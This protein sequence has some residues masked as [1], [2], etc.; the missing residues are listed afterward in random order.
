ML[1]HVPVP[2]L[3]YQPWTTADEL[4]LPRGPWQPD[5]TPRPVVPTAEWLAE[6][7]PGISTA[8]FEGYYRTHSEGW[9]AARATGVGGSDVAAIV[10]CSKWTSRY[11]LWALR[12][13]KVERVEDRKNLN[14]KRWGSRLEAVLL[15]EFA[16]A[17]PELLVLTWPDGH[18]AA[19]VHS[20]RAY[21]RASPDALA[22]DFDTGLWH[23]VEVK[24]ARYDD[25]W[26]DPDTWALTVPRYYTTQDQWY[27][28]AF[29]WGDSFFA[30]LFTGSDYR[31]L[32]V[33]A[34]GWEQEVNRREVEAFLEEVRTGAAPA[35]D[36]HPGTLA[37]VRRMHPEIERD[38]VIELDDEGRVLVAAYR[39]MV[40]AESEYRQASAVVLAKMGQAHHGVNGKVRVASRQAQG[41]GAPF[42]KM[43]VK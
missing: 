20:E 41:K 24:T 32:V 39:A 16:E 11:E 17:H 7:I 23:I 37:T 3:T 35:M 13:G 25:E 19:F 38:T 21:Q 43:K 5:E 29:G 9:H 4:T 34:D 2:A 31:E 1:L 6:V 8:R 30:V 22:Y 15:E 42:L 14:E 36:E 27:L 12:T 18:G 28:D 33:P 40:S 10:G 26:R